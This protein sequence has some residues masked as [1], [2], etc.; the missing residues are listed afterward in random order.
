[1]KT[2]TEKTVAALSALAL[3]AG[4][5]IPAFA[6]TNV[7][8]ST[9]VDAAVNSELGTGVRNV[10]NAIVGASTSVKAS[11]S[12]NVSTDA[13]TDT[14]GSAEVSD[15]KD[16]SVIIVSRADVD[17]GTAGATSVSVADVQAD[18]DLSGYVAAQIGSDKNIARV[19]TSA[20]TVSVTYKQN[21]K[22]LG[23]IP[24]TVNATATVDATGEVDVSYPWYTFL[25]VT[26]ET[27]LEASLESRIDSALA[28]GVDAEAAAELG[29][30]TQARLIN[31]IK[32]VMAAE[33]AADVNA[34]VSANA[35][36]NKIDGMTI[37]Q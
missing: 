17:A 31:E 25:A 20:D 29:A 35:R 19:A 36:V 28:L 5:A 30:N 18:A 9:G 6:E 11:G 3:S 37:K 10:V 13:D 32:T 21:V 23:F 15:R 1:M 12:A 16:I 7:Y 14:D 4:I 22:F 34:D 24:A 26:N 33:L 2:I 8:G 27:D